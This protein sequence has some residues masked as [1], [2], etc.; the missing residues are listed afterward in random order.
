[1]TLGSG[2]GLPLS[3]PLCRPLWCGVTGLVAVKV[4]SGGLW[5]HPG[6]GRRH[7]SSGQPPP[8]GRQQPGRGLWQ[9]GWVKERGC[10]ERPSQTLGHPEAK[11]KLQ[12]CRRTVSG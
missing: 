10:E 4:V 11:E 3:E 8:G 7:V 12:E 2:P 9:A 5:E 1:M 6:V